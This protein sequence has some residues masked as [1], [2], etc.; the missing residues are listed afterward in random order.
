MKRVNW[1]KLFLRKDVNNLIRKELLAIFALLT[2]V[3]CSNDKFVEEGKKTSTQDSEKN[4]QEIDEEELQK[5]Q[6]KIYEQMKRPMNEV[7]QDN[8]LDELSTMDTEVNEELNSYEDPQEFA[9]RVG[10]VMYEFENG[11]IT[12]EEY[13][14]F[15]KI[16]TGE[17]YA[18]KEL[19]EDRDN[20]IEV[21]RSLQET[22]KSNVSLESYELT[23]ITFNRSEKEGYFYRKIIGESSEYFYITTIVKEDN[24]WKM[25][26]DSPSPPYK[27]QNTLE[28]GD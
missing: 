28:T 2:I 15:L 24:V 27:G 19:L 9:K 13:A 6:N 11:S 16:H 7:I 1:F 14:D 23:T 5:E 8:D 12:P 21:L 17:N 18:Q 10:K 22:Y 3:G 26:D 25:Q 20:A 4:E